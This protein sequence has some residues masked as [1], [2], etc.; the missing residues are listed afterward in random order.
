MKH[1]KTT[2]S[3]AHIGAAL[4]EQVIG[5]R[6]QETP[7]IAHFSGDEIR[8]TLSNY[9]SLYQTEILGAS[10][11]NSTQK[12]GPVRFLFG[13]CSGC[14]VEPETQIQSDS[15]FLPVKQGDQL[16]IRI[17][18][19][20]ETRA[21]S[22]QGLTFARHSEAGDYTM[23]PVFPV[24]DEEIWVFPKRPFDAGEP[25]F[26]L[27]QIDILTEQ[28]GISLAV[29]GDSNGFMRMWTAPLEKMMEEKGLPCVVLN[30]SIS[31]NRLLSDTAK[32]IPGQLFGFS[33]KRRYNIDINSLCGLTHIIFATGGNDLYQPG[34]MAAPNDS[35]PSAQELFETLQ[36]LNAKAKEK[37]LKTYAA[38]LTPFSGAEGTPSGRQEI[39]KELNRKLL[40]CNE[41]DAILDF[42]AWLVEKDGCGMDSRFD[43]GDHLHINPEGGKLIAQKSMNYI[44]R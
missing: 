28:E 13:S 14:I 20:P 1:W 22:G 11:Y 30:Q 23:E 42:Y 21:L 44:R 38:T 16:M 8:I 34:T 10:V 17:A 35:V 39:Q 12:T 29:L 18:F 40:E 19:A 31:G 3:L 33:A 32:E 6:T 5:N 36:M 43:S 4:Y 15:A 7:V 25:T 37:G 26:L 2:F 41:F 24:S 27:S 9:Y